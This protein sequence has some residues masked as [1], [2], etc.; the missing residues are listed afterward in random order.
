MSNLGENCMT[1]ALLA[2]ALDGELPPRQAWLVKLHVESCESCQ[3]RFEELRRV[4]SQVAALHHIAVVP[5]AGGRFTALLDEEESRQQRNPAWWGWFARP[6]WQ[7]LAWC[8]ALVVVILAGMRVRTP[9]PPAAVLP[10][11]RRSPLAVAPPDSKQLISAATP[12]KVVRRV[13]RSG[14]KPVPDGAIAAREEVATP[15][16]A[17]PFSD[18]ALPLDQA[19]VIRVDLPRS[20]LELAGLP[21]EEDRRNERVR[22]DLVLGA[23]GLAR[24]IRFVE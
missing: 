19:T 21:V 6:M 14:K 1:D 17:L 18:A 7:R 24:A 23:D 5:S 9:H 3:A 12:A 4:S 20:A 15:F 2:G 11:V 10:V 16:F 8:A 13:R 22:A